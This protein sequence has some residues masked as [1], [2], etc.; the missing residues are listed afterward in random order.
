M[1]IEIWLNLLICSV[2]IFFF[3]FNYEVIRKDRY[4]GYGGVLLVIK[5]DFIIDLVDINIILEVVFVKLYLGKNLLIIIG[6]VYRLLFSK[7][8]YI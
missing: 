3:V 1:G 4:D 2:E 5:K 7:E 6:S 8:I